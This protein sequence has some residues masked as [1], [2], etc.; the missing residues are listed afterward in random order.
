MLLSSFPD[1]MVSH[2]NKTHSIVKHY[3]ESTLRLDDITFLKLVVASFRFVRL[4]AAARGAQNLL[5]P[6]KGGLGT[7][8]INLGIKVGSD[9]FIP[10]SDFFYGCIVHI[11]CGLDPLGHGAFHG[12]ELFLRFGPQTFN[13]GL[14]L[15]TAMLHV[16]NTTH[17]LADV[18]F[19]KG[20]QRLVVA[21]AIVYL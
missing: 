14:F 9:I 3:L 1:D 17:G 10:R 15:V 16:M 21:F 4:A 5:N 19:S 7:D 18:L 2:K 13:D 8:H 12:L 20:C 6:L 11:L